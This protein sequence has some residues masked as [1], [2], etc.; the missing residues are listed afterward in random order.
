MAYFNNLDELTNRFDDDDYA[1]QSLNGAFSE[2][3]STSIYG[4]GG[5]VVYQMNANNLLSV[6][7]DAHREA[8]NS[9]GF[10]RGSVTVGPVNAG[11]ATC[12]ATCRTALNSLCSNIGGTV[13]DPKQQHRRI[14][15]SGD[16]KLQQRGHGFQYR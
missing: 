3:A 5:Q 10:Q 15:R 9:D 8:W 1:T 16:G 11:G 7:L 12:N 14:W 4:G 13:S 6:A 2:D